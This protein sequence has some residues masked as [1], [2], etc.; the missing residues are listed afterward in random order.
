VPDN[1]I[2]NSPK[3]RVDWT[4]PVW[5][6]VGLLIQGI[7][8]VWFVAS[9]NA[10]VEQTTTR[11][12]KIEAHMVTVDASNNSSDATLARIDERTRTMSDDIGELRHGRH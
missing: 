1:H 5:G 8:L 10:K 9:L 2:V 3:L 6:V 4:V 11:V 12:D 7:A